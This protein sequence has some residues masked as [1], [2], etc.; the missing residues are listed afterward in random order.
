VE[1]AVVEAEAADGY[2]LAKAVL[3]PW[4]HTDEERQLNAVI[5]EFSLV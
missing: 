1:V 5:Y 4:I 3:H 2:N